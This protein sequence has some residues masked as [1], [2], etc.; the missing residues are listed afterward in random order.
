MQSQWQ[1][2]QYNILS[3]SGIYYTVNTQYY[4]YIT[5]AFYIIIIIIIIIIYY[6]SPLPPTSSREDC[7]QCTFLFVEEKKGRRGEMK[8]LRGEKR[9]AA[10]C[11]LIEGACLIRLMR[12][13]ELIFPTSLRALVEIPPLSRIVPTPSPWS[14]TQK[15]K[16]NER[17]SVR[18]EWTDE[19]GLCPHIKS[20]SLKGCS[21]SPRVLVLESGLCIPSLCVFKCK[22]AFGISVLEPP[23]MRD[24]QM[25]G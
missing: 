8:L 5:T 2:R 4:L 22:A 20:S 13:R 19:M 14:I 11:K 12:W 16:W 9:W 24:V 25:C 1:D 17:G 15:E 6:Y 23:D 21:G 7:M 18:G 3:L 10:S